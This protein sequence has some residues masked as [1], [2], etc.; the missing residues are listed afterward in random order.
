MVHYVEVDPL[1]KY[2]AQ[3]DVNKDMSGRMCPLS[4][5]GFD[6]TTNIGVISGRREFKVKKE[7]VDNWAFQSP[8]M[9]DMMNPVLLDELEGLLFSLTS[10]VF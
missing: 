7:K 10:L 2:Q 6:C 3:A 8:V 1:I 4:H 5:P 9:E